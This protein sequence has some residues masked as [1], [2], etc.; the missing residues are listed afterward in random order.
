MKAVL[1]ARQK[2]VPKVGQTDTLK[3]D[4]LVACWAAMR[5]AWWAVRWAM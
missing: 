4:Y 2:V 3:A 1:L 5:A